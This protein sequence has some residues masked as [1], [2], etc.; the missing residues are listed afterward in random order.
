M[1]DSQQ[2]F[3]PVPPQADI[4]I[5]IVT[6]ADLAA[7]SMGADTMLP[8]TDPA[9]G[10]AGGAPGAVQ[11][12]P[13][14]GSGL[15]FVSG[16]LSRSALQTMLGTLTPGMKKMEAFRQTQEK[17]MQPWS[18]FFGSQNPR[19]AFGIGHPQYIVPRVRSNLTRYKWNYVALCGATVAL[20]ALFSF[21]FFVL[22]LGVLALWAYVFFWRAEP[23]QLFGHALSR[24]QI[25][26]GL[27]VLTAL[28]SYIALGQK[29]FVIAAIDA[30]FCV[31]HSL[32]RVSQ[33]ET[34]DF[35]RG[36]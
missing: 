1:S 5:P 30:I 2:E 10:G 22:G 12:A 11:G 19:A 8:L 14:Q 29:L 15:S 9:A 35:S 36:A 24:S 26:V 18:E 32:F 27:C 33:E 4:S 31:L 25:T 34:I 6:P 21:T 28:V 13:A 3:A 16:L 20:L 17:A 7:S 23:V